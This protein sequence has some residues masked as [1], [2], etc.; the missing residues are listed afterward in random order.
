MLKISS[1]RSTIGLIHLSFLCVS[2][3][4]LRIFLREEYKF[5][6]L[7]WNLFL[8]WTPFWLTNLAEKVNRY[9]LKFSTLTVGLLF[10]PNSPY[11]ITDLLHL[12]NYDQNIIWFDSLLIFIFAFTG[13]LI[14]LT[15]LKK[16]HDILKNHFDNLLAWTI[17]CT[18]TFLSGFGIYL[19]RYC[20]L[21]S[22]DLFHRPSWFLGRI[23]HQFENPLSY[24]MTLTFGFILFGVYYIFHNFTLESRQ[25]KTGLRK[26]D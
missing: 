3:I 5:S 11:M 6:F 21:N 20:R 14:G 12:K 1:N 9:F 13:L 17:I 25:D 19:G 2:F 8:A 15:S 18:I 22:W 16:G 10:F 23:L 7:I 24:K 26:I 4:C